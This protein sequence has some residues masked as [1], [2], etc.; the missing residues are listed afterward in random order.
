MLSISPK[1][2]VKLA[3]CGVKFGAEFCSHH[4]DNLV[5]NMFRYRPI[6]HESSSSVGASE[7][8]SKDTPE[9]VVG[10]LGGMTS[11]GVKTVG[12]V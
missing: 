12:E 8:A 5:E 3:L 6:W 9:P 2:A 11:M 1:F 10:F 4:G 7:G